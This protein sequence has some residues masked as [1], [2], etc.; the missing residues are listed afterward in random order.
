M[1]S[2][3][4]SVETRQGEWVDVSD[5]VRTAAAL[6]RIEDGLCIIDCPHPDAAVVVSDSD[7]EQVKQM[8]AGKTDGEGI[9]KC[10]HRCP[11]GNF[12]TIKS[13]HARLG[14]DIG[15]RTWE[16]VSSAGAGGVFV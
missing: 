16:A 5:K 13:R 12:G 3:D 1:P 15:D 6:S 7:H 11:A 14:A 2:F 10:F 4:F 8:V 9:G